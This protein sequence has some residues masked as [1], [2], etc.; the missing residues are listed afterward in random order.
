MARFQDVPV[1]LV[2]T[3]LGFS[4][5][6]SS[7]LLAQRTDRA[8]ISGVVTDAQGAAVPGATV[9][10]TN[11]GTGVEIIL[12]ANSA[13]AYKT[14]PLVLGTY[15]V[16]VNLAGFKTAQT[17]GIELTAADVVRHDVILEVGEV[18]ETVE[19]VSATG[20]L[21]S[22][23]PDVSHSVDE[24]FYRDLPIITAADVRLAESV[25]LMQPGY[26]PMTPNGDPMFRGSQF[27]SRING[28][29]ARAVENFFDGG[30]FGYA[31]GHQGSQESAPPVEAI[32]E[33][34]VVTTTYSA[35]YGHTS[36]GFIEY[37]SKSGSNTFHGS[38]YSF[39]AD[40]SLNA[41]GFFATGR[42][43]LRNRTLGVTLGGPIVKNKTFFFVNFDWTKF[44][45]GVLPGFGN[46]TPID[47]FKGGDFSALLTN[48]QIGTD[49][50]GRPIFAG[51][52]FNPSTTR[53]VNGVTVRDPYP[54]NVIPADDPL[55]SLVSAQ[56]TSLMVSPD[57][58]GL[59]NNVAGNP[60]GDQTWDLDA[61]VYLARL[62]HNFTPDTRLSLSGFYNN[63]PSIRNCGGV[64][65]CT[66]QFD[67]QTEPEKNVDYYGNGFYQRIYT[68]HGHA[69][70]DWVINNNLM[71]HSHMSWD[72]WQMGGNSLSAGVGWGQR[73]WGSKEQAGIL[74]DDGGPPV[75]NFNGNIPYSE[76][77]QRWARYGYEL[78]DRW[79]FS[80]DLTWITG[81]NTIKA[82][83]EYRT[84]SYPNNGW[85][86]GG[87][88]SP[89]FRF[90]RLGT[91][92]YDA[93][94]NNLSQTGDPFASF[95]L[96]QVHDSEQQIPVYPEFHEK[97]FSPWING[98]FKVG[99]KLTLQAGLRLDYQFGRTESN[100]QYST[101]DPNTP[102]PG[103]GGRPGALIYAGTGPGRSGR[104]EFEDPGFFDAL[105]PRAGFAY[106]L[107]DKTTIRGGYG[108]YYANVA[109]SQFIG[110]PTAGFSSN[111][112]A[113]NLTNGQFPSFD[114][115]DGFPSD[116]IPRPPFVDPTFQNGG[117]ILWVPEDGL[118][119]P[120]FQNWSVTVKRRLTDNI[121]LDVSYIGNKGT[122]LNHHWERNGLAANMNDPAVLA[123]G[124]ALLNSPADSPAAQAAGI[125][126]P[127]PGFTGNVAQALRAYPQYQGVQSRSVPLGRSQYHALELV[128]EQRV[129]KGL[130]YRIGYTFSRL[131]NNGAESGQGSEGVNGN[132]QDPVN[133]DSADWGL[134][135]DDTPHV[136]L[137][138][139]TWDLPTNDSW[140]GFK[141]AVLNGW[142][143]SGILRYESGRPQNIFMANDMGGFLFNSQKRP[144]TAGGDPVAAG[145]DFDPN[146]DRYF[147]RDAWTDPGPL[148]FGNA[149]RADGDARG[150]KVFSEDINVS[151]SF[152]LTDRARLRFEA[153][154]GNIF[155]R[156]T[157]LGPERNFSSGSFGLVSGQANQARSIQLGVRLD[158]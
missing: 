26:L 145:G 16:K 97:Y 82:G 114:L 41:Q 11:Q 37:T 77:G 1:R 6:L 149:P 116:A 101:F 90:N 72:R 137:V 35:E 68:I 89:I 123:L 23:R 29:Q 57:R 112:L 42:T 27:N 40:D 146:A 91:G 38:L 121:M 98:E 48:N 151:K 21:D 79:Q 84:H 14:N 88:T 22:T 106:Q 65:G 93:Q 12:Q 5:F 87:E 17:T 62:D 130:Q 36:G 13:G 43:P 127:Y 64:Q 81:R 31:S 129:T 30:A 147:N 122:R 94:G 58:P 120:R 28:G 32:Q 53:T 128:L 100:D 86:G 126:L 60:A 118:K 59:S 141:K 104:R 124:A 18:T 8:V 105:G 111:Y 20:G 85:G 107:N 140:T 117:N 119:L 46:T 55:R 4:S 50:L 74:V 138:G 125:A 110:A 158:Y 109:F 19:V 73:L 9:T 24:K 113:A 54:G 157:F 99:K 144:N 69:Q 115:D 52:I 95:L 10:V 135:V 80:T 15:S 143:I 34:T 67:G 150:F 66:T 142:N 92:G 152:Q 75:I 136:L 131:N 3:V 61:K 39:F 154:F 155:N 132:V 45:S 148:A 76:L 51:Q 102:N 33:V 96:G 49:A 63:R 134:S 153:Q 156:T 108:M 70:F 133:W 2:L 71:S 25:L 7:P 44:E 83:I 56:I 103:A 139:F 78:N 47:A